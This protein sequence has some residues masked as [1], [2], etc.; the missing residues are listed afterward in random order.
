MADTDNKIKLDNQTQEQSTLS[1]L[2]E[3]AISILPSWSSSPDQSKT[4]QQQ[5]QAG[6]CSQTGQ[7]V[8]CCNKNKPK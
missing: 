7:P 8:C 3:T 4:A 2:Y 6:G 1:W 5:V